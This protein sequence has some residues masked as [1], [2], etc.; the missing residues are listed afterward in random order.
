MELRISM[1]TRSPSR[2]CARARH[3]GIVTA[4]RC[5]RFGISAVGA[6]VWLACLRSRDW[7]SHFFGTVNNRCSEPSAAR[8]ARARE[9]AG[10]SRFVH[11]VHR[12]ETGAGP[13]HRSQCRACGRETASVS[14]RKQRESRLSARRRVTNVRHPV[15]AETRAC[16]VP[17][18]W[19]VSTSCMLTHTLIGPARDEA[20][21]PQ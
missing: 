14:A 6:S 1:A 16:I 18:Q 2:A 7:R 13:N 3:T 8:A 17:P 15:P 4:L 21:S 9:F 20:C 5:F 10:S 11:L 12:G 19:L